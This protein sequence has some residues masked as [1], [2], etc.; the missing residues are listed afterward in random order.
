META[1]LNTE[2][3]QTIIDR[4]HQ[5][6]AEQA[7][8]EKMLLTAQLLIAEIG[9]SNIPVRERQNVAV[10]MPATIEV[11]TLKPEPVQEPVQEP[12][13]EIETNEQ[14]QHQSVE[15]SKPVLIQE[16][17]GR[18]SE[19]VPAEKHTIEEDKHFHIWEAFG[20]VTEPPT[21][22]HYQPKTETSEL[23]EKYTAKQKK[24][25]GQSLQSTPIHDLT[26]AVGINDRYLFI[27]ELF[28]GDEF[29]FE[30]SIITLNRFQSYEQAQGWIER[31]LRLKLG[32]DID[33]PVT[34]QFEILISRRFL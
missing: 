7:G 2:K 34:K 20:I 10:V 19:A 3:I 23:N 31:E 29:M 26:T 6:L 11:A 14:T 28:R 15:T 25:L 30:R 13:E 9:R 18:E 17:A 32:W 4:L 12:V 21:I 16:E 8:K 1:I 24:E 33:N 22:T 5:Q 27:N